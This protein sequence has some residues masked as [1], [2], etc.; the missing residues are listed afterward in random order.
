[1]ARGNSPGDRAFRQGDHGSNRE[2]GSR[3]LPPAEFVAKWQEAEASARQ[4][5]LD[6]ELARVDAII[7]QE[8][9][10]LRFGNPAEGNPLVATLIREGKEFPGGQEHRV[11]LFSRDHLVKVTHPGRYGFIRDTPLDY[12][13][14]LD[15]L[16][17]LSPELDLRILGAA[18]LAELPSIISIMKRIRGRHPSPQE[19]ERILEEQGWEPYIEPSAVRAEMLA[20][21]H[22]ELNAT[23]WDAHNENFILTTNG[24]LIPIDVAV[25]YH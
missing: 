24:K 22:P 7:A 18:K 5:S 16:A 2:T 25:E 8:Q 6:T 20:Y 13:F 23:M 15:N 1:M 19:L 14:R 10:L 17:R 11:F 9:A 12:L 3:G 21:R 4:G